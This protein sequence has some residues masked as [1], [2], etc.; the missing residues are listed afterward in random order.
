M[1][2]RNGFGAEK[3]E[4]SRDGKRSRQELGEIRLIGAQ[5][6]RSE[7]DH[8]LGRICASASEHTIPQRGQADAPGVL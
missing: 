8:G 2:K 6:E 4:S 3:L 7:V 5:E 1:G